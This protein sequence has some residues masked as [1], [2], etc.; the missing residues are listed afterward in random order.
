MSDSKQ[1]EYR[2]IPGIA[3][4]VEIECETFPLRHGRRRASFVFLSAG[5]P[6]VRGGAVKWEELPVEVQDAITAH[7]GAVFALPADAR[8]AYLDAL[9]PWSVMAMTEAKE[10]AAPQGMVQRRP[11]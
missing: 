11:S 7:F 10:D 6:P 3:S 9:A 4:I 5:K 8:G 2:I 1:I